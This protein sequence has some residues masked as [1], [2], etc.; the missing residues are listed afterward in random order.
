MEIK[1]ASQIQIGG[2]H[3]KELKMSP[4]KYI[5]ANKL[6]YCLGNVVKYI[7]R[8]KGSDA[9]KINDLL[10]AKHYIDLELEERYKVDENGKP[11]I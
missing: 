11:L 4:L 9:D 7:S 10:K 6:S 2:S 8:N 5:L 3:Y 1:K